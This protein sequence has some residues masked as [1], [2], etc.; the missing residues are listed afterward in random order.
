MSHTKNRKS[1]F[2][3]AKSSFLLCFLSLVS[4]MKA[5]YKNRIIDLDSLFIYFYFLVV[6]TVC[7]VGP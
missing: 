6:T 1:S 5:D 2:G 4:P 7:V 3:S